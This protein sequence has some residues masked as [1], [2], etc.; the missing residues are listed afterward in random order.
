M[1][2]PK[3]SLTLTCRN[4]HANRVTVRMMRGRIDQRYE[5]VV[6]GR[7]VGWSFPNEGEA[8]DRAYEY[9]RAPADSAL[10]GCC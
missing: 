6:Q 8:L 7:V 9:L 2:L 5:T 4:G 1:T 10:G 3:R